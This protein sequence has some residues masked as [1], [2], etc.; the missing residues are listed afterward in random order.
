MSTI[1]EARIP[2]WFKLAYT[3]FCAVLVPTYL[4][5]YGPTNFLYFCDVA[6]LTALAAIWLESPLLAS[7]PAVGILLPQAL[8]VVDFLAAAVGIEL[9]GL[10]AYMFDAK[11]PLFTR[12]LSFF[13]FW[14]PFV[15]AWL[16]WRLGYDRRAFAVWTVA[17]WVLLSICYF[18]MPPPP[19]THPNLP[20][21]INYVFGLSDAAAQSFM[22]GPLWFAM[23]LVGLPAIIFY[24]THR[25]LLRYSGNRPA[26]SPG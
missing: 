26:G 1:P 18:L 8:W 17:A 15:L 2:L 11:L 22:P 14:L 5:V 21:N 19:A 3:V 4:I 23:L 13:H 20:A 16:V 10:T 6:L 12:G 9:T 7:V 24:P 25:L